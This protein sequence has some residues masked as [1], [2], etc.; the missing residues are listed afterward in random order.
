MATVRFV[1]SALDLEQARD[2]RRSV[3]CGE[4][5]WDRSVVD[6]GSDP[7]DGVALGWEGG[8]PAA[9]GRLARRGERAWLELLAVLPALRRRGLA[10]AVVSLLGQRA[11]AA[12]STEIWALAPA[13]SV[14]AFRGLG[15]LPRGGEDDVFLM[16]KGLG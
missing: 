8:K 7:G 13:G 6:D 12:G 5:N 15:F 4:M 14:P 2:L 3:F 1:E 10:S 9:T 16:A 11:K